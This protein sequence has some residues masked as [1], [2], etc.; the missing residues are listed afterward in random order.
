MI[1]Y[2]ILTVLFLIFITFREIS[3][4]KTEKDLLNRIMSKDYS[5]Y[6]L[7]EL[8]KDKKTESINIPSKRDEVEKE[9]T[10]KYGPNEEV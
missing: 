10:K 7:G 6:H 3:F 2:L 9:I 4:R 1:Y 8:T 5:E